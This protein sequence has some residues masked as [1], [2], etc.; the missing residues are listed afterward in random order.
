MSP[1]P[2][3]WID[4]LFARL[5]VRYGAAWGRMYEGL[6]LSAVKADW[7]RELG[8]YAGNPDA[9]KY[10]LDHLPSDWPPNVAQ[11]KAICLN[12]PEPAPL[13]IAAPKPDKARLE[14]ELFKL[15][16][17]AK[18]NPLAWAYAL[19]DREKRGEALTGAQRWAWREALQDGP[20]AT[21]VMSEFTPIPADVLPPAM[22]QEAM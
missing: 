18:V 7:A 15:A 14:A 3:E 22:R 20:K 12:R 21:T 19:Q 6:E 2:S 10:A 4:S 13:Q 16:K 5:S 8:A 1:L 17:P 9:I 11:F